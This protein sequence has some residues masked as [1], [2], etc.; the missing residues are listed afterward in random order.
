MAVVFYAM[1]RLVRMPEQ[2]RARDFHH[3]YSWSASLIVSPCSFGANSSLSAS[4]S[5]LPFFGLILFEYELLRK[6][7][8]SATSP[9]LPS[10]PHSPVFSSPTSPRAIPVFFGTTA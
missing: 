10:L 1:S 4:P 2:W 5:A 9:T 6:S 7:R 8:N 3:I